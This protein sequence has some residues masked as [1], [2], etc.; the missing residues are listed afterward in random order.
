[1]KHDMND[2]YGIDIDS[3]S[4]ITHQEYGCVEVSSGTRDYLFAP[5]WESAGR[6]V[7]SRWQ[8]MAENDPGEFTACVG[9]D[10]LV[11]WALGQSAGPGS[12]K[13]RSLEEWLDL[14]AEHPDEELASYDGNSIEIDGHAWDRDLVVF[15]R[16]MQFGLFSENHDQI[17]LLSL[18][19]EYGEWRAVVTLDD[20]KV[21][22]KNVFSPGWL[23]QV[24]G[25]RALL[26][27]EGVGSSVSE[28]IEDLWEQI[29]DETVFERVSAVAA[30]SDEIDSPEVAFRRN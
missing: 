8:E 17:D 29:Q 22:A 19:E 12:A 26:S 7:R 11:A 2:V 15:S 24:P 5:D 16:L 6:L 3:A 20:S 1:M 30:I 18:R 14:A 27:L 28:A 13:V 21:M 9:A 10:T 25:M 4:H 23:R